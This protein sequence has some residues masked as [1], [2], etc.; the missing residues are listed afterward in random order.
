MKQILTLL[1]ILLS[2]AGAKDT[3]FDERDFSEENIAKVILEN[4][5][6]YN[7]DPRV[8]YNIINIESAFKP[9]AIA[10]ETSKKSAMM[11]KE[12]KSENIDILVGR[13]YHSRI[14][15]VSIFPKRLEDAVFMV[16]LLKDLKFGFDVGS[17]QI[18]TCNFSKKEARYM[19]DPKVNIA[20]GASIL[21]SCMSQ[22][23]SKTHFIECY[24]RGAGNLRKSLRK[25]KHYYPYYKQYVKK[26]DF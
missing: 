21:K 18:N 9:Y 11:L 25:G 7:I 5:K 26:W 19:L 23:K 20:K 16:N 3:S 8:I 2:V 4:A 24:N 12:L 22:F 6:K 1:L 10:V 13:T 15:L 14:W 17:M